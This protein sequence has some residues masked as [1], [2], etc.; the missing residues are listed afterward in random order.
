MPPLTKAESEAAI[1][2]F[3]SFLRFE[4][5]SQTAPETGAYEKC[6]AFLIEQLTELKVL[7]DIHFLPEGPAHS[8]VVV[9]K[10]DGKDPTLP[11][12]LLN[13]HYDVVPAAPEDWSVPPFAAVRKDGRI[14]ARG[15]QDMKS[16]GMQY[17][18]AV[19][20]LA[21]NKPAWRPERSCYLTFVPDEEC[22]G[23][24]MAA[25]LASSLYRDTIVKGHGGIALALDEGLAS[26]DGAFSVFYG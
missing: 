14:Y 19:R 10:W 13:S 16:V 5:V 17:L 18:E 3:Q 9:A 1:R 24:G 4:T 25:F 6:A 22:G 26:T 11:V 8:P 12:L 23:A 2:R 15:T 20:C 7:T 21:R